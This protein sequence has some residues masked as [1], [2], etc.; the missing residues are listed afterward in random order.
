M[1]LR[2]IRSSLPL[3]V[4][5]SLL[6]I[7]SVSNARGTD[8]NGADGVVPADAPLGHLGNPPESLA[9]RMREAS[10]QTEVFLAP[11]YPV[12]SFAILNVSGLYAEVTAGSRCVI[13]V[14]GGCP[15]K[16]RDI[17]LPAEQVSCDELSHN[18]EQ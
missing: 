7:F 15:G 6:F 14:L 16:A 1:L 11:C 10:D 4:P 5:T 8:C 13:S 18:G 17:V 3:P 2:T 9:M 12:P